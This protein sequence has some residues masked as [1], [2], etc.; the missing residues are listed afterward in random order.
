[1]TATDTCP[2]CARK[3]VPG[4]FSNHLRLSRD[5]RCAS[6]R[7][8]LRPS[9]PS[10]P[11]QEPPH[12]PTAIDI[13]MVDLGNMESSA[14]LEQSDRTNM[15]TDPP[16]HRGNRVCDEYPQPV[17]DEAP[18]LFVCLPNA[19]ASV[20]FDSD[21]E[22]SDDDDGDQDR[23][24]TPPGTTNADNEGVSQTGGLAHP[25]YSSGTNQ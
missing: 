16:D 8:L 21:T 15:D 17:L 24:E 22:D 1:M 7:D 4:G 25:I 11:D 5:P 6:V 20:I 10:V 14:L 2:G 12:S 18:D 13:E 23:P 9:Y 19:R 3:F